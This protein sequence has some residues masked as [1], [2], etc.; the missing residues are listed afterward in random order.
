[1]LTLKRYQKLISFQ[2]VSFLNLERFPLNLS[3]TITKKNYSHSIF[4]ALTGLIFK[5]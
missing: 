2:T 5:W 3:G 1:M 4:F